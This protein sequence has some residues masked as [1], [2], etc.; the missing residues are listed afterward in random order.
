ME[1]GA[2]V[3]SKSF[4]GPQEGPLRICITAK[5][6]GAPAPQS[7]RM[8]GPPCGTKGKGGPRLRDRHRDQGG[9]PRDPYGAPQ[10]PVWGPPGTPMGTPGGPYGAP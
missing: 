7:N 10:G 1:G 2:P 6:R 8:R 3:K 5:S 9:P 4:K